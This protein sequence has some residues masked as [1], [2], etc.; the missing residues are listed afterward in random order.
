MT[1]VDVSYPSSSWGDSSGNNLYIADGSRSTIIK[2]NFMLSTSTVFAGMEYSNYNEDTGCEGCSATSSKIYY[3]EQVWGNTAGV[4]YITTS[5]SAAVGARSVDTS[6]KIHLLSKNCSTNSTG[7]VGDGGRATS[8]CILG[9]SGLW[10][11]TQ[12]RVYL[13]QNNNYKIRLIYNGI[14]TTFAGTGSFGNDGNGG[15]ATS[16]SFTPSELWG[17]VSS[18]A[19]NNALYMIDY[20][21]NLVK[22]ISLSSAIISVFAGSNSGLAY[23][24][25]DGGPAT[26]ASLSNPTGLWTDSVY[27]DLYIADSG[28]YRLRKVTR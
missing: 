4:V 1:Y 13:A 24:Q 28:N 15:A 16:A 23:P 8:A 21:Y 26:S 18:V 6:G 7:G 27:G 3:P 17:S 10:G 5:G 14:V 9:V 20:S 12:G 19:T 25:G 11:D 22:K 2:F